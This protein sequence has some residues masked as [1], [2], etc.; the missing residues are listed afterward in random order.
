MAFIAILTSVISTS[1]YL[2]IIILL[3]SESKSSNKNDKVL[4][5]S[6][7]VFNNE[8][9]LTNFHSFLISI[10]TLF[11]L[12]FIFKPNLI[13]NSTQLLTLSLFYH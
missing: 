12:L 6:L 9:I 8:W 1:Y 5:S 3:I 4:N 10:L 11:I 2:R 7:N 13:L